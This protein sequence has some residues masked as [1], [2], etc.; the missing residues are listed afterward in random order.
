MQL[1]VFTTSTFASTVDALLPTCPLTFATRT[2]ASSLTPRFRKICCA[3]ITLSC[4]LSHLSRFCAAVIESNRKKRQREHATY[5][6]TIKVVAWYEFNQAIC[7]F[8]MWVSHSFFHG[9]VLK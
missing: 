1:E 4:S 7:A 2:L 8:R 9:L 5:I 3:F 6:L